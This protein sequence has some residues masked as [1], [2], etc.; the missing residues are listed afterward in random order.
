MEEGEQ[1]EVP[2]AKALSALSEGLVGLPLF[3]L[4]GVI[5]FP[6]QTIQVRAGVEYRRGIPAWNTGALGCEARAARG[7]C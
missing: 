2:S 6:G 5:L 1:E 7:E 4:E 3:P